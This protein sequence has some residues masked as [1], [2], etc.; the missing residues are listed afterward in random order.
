MPLQLEALPTEI[1]LSITTHLTSHKDRFHF[2]R[3]S[4]RLFDIVYP[5]TFHSI[6][7]A[8]YCTSDL[9]WLIH[10]FLREQKACLS[11][12]SLVLGRPIPCSK[13]HVHS[14]DLSTIDDE[15]VA[16]VD[17]LVNYYTGW[18]IWRKE[19]RRSDNCDA[20][21]ALMLYILV[22]L[23]SIEWLWVESKTRYAAKL[24]DEVILRRDQFQGS[25]PL[26]K[27]EKVLLK[28]TGR[29]AG[30]IGLKKILPFVY[31]PS[32]HVFSA[33][34]VK[35]FEWFLP[36]T[37]KGLCSS[38]V[39]HLE[40]RQ[41]TTRA[42]FARLIKLC[43][44]LRS[45]KYYYEPGPFMF[46]RTATVIAQLET[47]KETLETLCLDS[48]SY[49]ML[50]GFE[51]QHQWVGSLRGFWRLR[52]LQLQMVHFFHDGQLLPPRRVVDLLPPSLETLCISG[53]WRENEAVMLAEMISLVHARD[54]FPHLSEVV[55]K[56]RFLTKVL[57]PGEIV[58][59]Q[60]W[61][62]PL[63]IIDGRTFEDSILEATAPL[64]S[65]CEKIGVFFSIKDYE[66]DARVQGY[67]D[68]PI[69]DLRPLFRQ[70]SI[71]V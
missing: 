53:W 48:D 61:P 21:L 17:E 39:T 22:N 43:T 49:S 14:R 64:R 37:K 54:E 10:F 3:C 26:G 33:Q 8:E 60:T 28:G 1:I 56:G 40:L 4:R 65:S 19:L 5:C 15:I 9:S 11:V 31:L 68:S 38:T 70:G 58:N 69:P 52:N 18:T 6:E 67:E 42:G 29:R 27:L 24:V 57:S 59:Y 32:L 20:W 30:M 12:E 71:W 51:R 7:L 44:G 16:E 66:V 25:G 46:E 36:E 55:I 23:R 63:P 41:S 2:A 34:M 62:Q 35:D 45:F 13:R 50:Q 47:R